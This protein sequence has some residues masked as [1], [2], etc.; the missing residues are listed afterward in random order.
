MVKYNYENY[1]NFFF[2]MFPDYINLQS[3]KSFIIS[4]HYYYFIIISYFFIFLHHASFQFGY[5]I[6]IWK[7]FLSG[8]Q[9]FILNFIF[10]CLNNLLIGIF[11]SF[12]LFHC[13]FHFGS[14]FY[15][16]LLY[17]SVPNNFLNF[18]FLV[19]YWFSYSINL[20][21]RKLIMNKH[22]FLMINIYE[23]S[24]Y[25]LSITAMIKMSFNYIYFL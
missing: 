1:F 25:L 12:T 3:L 21:A 6:L 9:M 16:I 20:N 17:I 5:W 4:N 10:H 13:W 8:N 14:N 23:Y 11:P 7:T 22:N 15:F 24:K 19:L 2:I 18:N